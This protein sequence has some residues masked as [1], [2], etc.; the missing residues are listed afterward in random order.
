MAASLM[1]KVIALTDAVTP[2][3][4]KAAAHKVGARPRP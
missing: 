3:V 1:S 2:D 4:V